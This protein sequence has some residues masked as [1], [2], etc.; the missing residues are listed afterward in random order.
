MLEPD[1][2]EETDKLYAALSEGGGA[3]SSMAEAS[4]GLFWLL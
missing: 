1:T 3:R 2:R 4:W